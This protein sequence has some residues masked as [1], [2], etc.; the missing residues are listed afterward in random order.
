MAVENVK[1]ALLK[2]DISFE[3]TIVCTNLFY[4]K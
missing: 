3:G 1:T 2:H 4:R